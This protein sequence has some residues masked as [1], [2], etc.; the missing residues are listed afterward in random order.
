MSGIVQESDRSAASSAEHV[1]P[2]MGSDAVA[3]ALRY[4]PRGALLV[5]GISTALLFL[6]WLAF[7]FL[8]FIPRGSVG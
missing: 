2:P 4:G 1:S 7:Y 3:E 8:L 6:G 5:A